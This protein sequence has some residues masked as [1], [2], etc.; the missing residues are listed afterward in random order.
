M[1]GEWR[2]SWVVC[3]DV[4]PHCACAGRTAAHHHWS[5]FGLVHS[6]RQDLAYLHLHH[7]YCHLLFALSCGS[8]VCVYVCVCVSVCVERERQRQRQADR[9]RQRDRTSV[10]FVKV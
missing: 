10:C 3:S 5:H 4:T 6:A 2:V 1:L 8:G 7:R 9:Q